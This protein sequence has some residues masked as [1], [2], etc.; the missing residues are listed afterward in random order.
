[1]EFAWWCEDPKSQTSTERDS[2]A[3]SGT[4]RHYAANAN[5]PNLRWQNKQHSNKTCFEAEGS[6]DWK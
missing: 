4:H 5:E 3:R 1:M 6:L 2:L